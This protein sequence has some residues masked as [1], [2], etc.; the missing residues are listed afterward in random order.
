M[1]WTAATSSVFASFMASMVEF[2]EALTIVLAVGIVRGWRSALY[3]VAAAVCVLALLVA[4]LGPMLTRI[5]IH[6]VRLVVGTLLL[7]FG[8]RWLAKAVLRSAGILPLHDEA[9]AFDKESEAMRR[10]GGASNSPFDTVAFIAVFKSVML[11]GIEVVFIVIALGAGGSLLMPAAGGAAL[12]LLLVLLLG[13]WLHRPLTRVPENALKFGVGVMLG[14]FGMFWVGEGLGIE[15]P[16]S[17][18]ALL[19]LVG[20]LFAVAVCSVPLCARAALRGRRY[21]KAAPPVERSSRHLSAMS[22]GWRTLSILFVDDGLLA[23]GIVLWVLCG[24][25]GLFGSLL[26]AGAVAATTFAGGLCAMLF[27]SVLRRARSISLDN[28][29]TRARPA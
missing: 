15:W 22:R 6:L 27:V 12:A 18:W 29:P 16:G 8:F 28:T 23:L 21:P 2:V 5:P 4:S 24:R 13:F 20:T 9:R 19:G 3:G 25:L 10:Q 11:E 26:P 14:A 7:L 1:Q 17:D